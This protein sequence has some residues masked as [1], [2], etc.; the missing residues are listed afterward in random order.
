MN[1]TFN[2]GFVCRPSKA[3]KQGK[4]PIE[5]TIIING[6][7]TYMALTRKEDPQDFQ[8]LSKSNKPNDLKDF[9]EATYRNVLRKETEMAQK[10]LPLTAQNLKEYIQ[11]GCTNSY[12]VED[13]FNEYYAI[14]KKRVGV[15]LTKGVYRKYELIKELF[16]KEAIA[17][18]RQATEISNGVI[19]SFYATLNQKYESTTSAA[20]MT[21]LKSVIIYAMDND[22]IQI[23]PFCGIKISRKTNPVEFLTEAEVRRIKKKKLTNERLIRVRDIFLFQCFT[24]LSYADMACLEPEDYQRNSQGQIYIKK[25]RCKTGVTFTAVL[26]PDA[27]AIAK[28]YDY[29][30]PML[31]NQKY[32]S[33]LKEIADLCDIKKPMHTH[34]GRHTAATYLLNKGLG[35]EIVAKILGHND[36][37]QTRHYAK[38]LDSTV[39]DAINKNF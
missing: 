12:T 27:E 26:L 4:A 18:N 17:P 6:K 16:F 2:I 3:N 24:G 15:D 28:K 22:R 8:K 35:L 37:R 31:S 14:L 10:G 9:L 25:E 34:I 1:T 7:R 38:L 13:L 39:F 29:K 19:S 20:M 23:N 30:L 36:T 33:Y 11:F 21:K 5:L 32:N